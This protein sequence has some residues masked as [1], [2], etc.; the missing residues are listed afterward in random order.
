MTSL[1]NLLI[2]FDYKNPLLLASYFSKTKLTVVDIAYFKAAS[3]CYSSADIIG[4]SSS[5]CS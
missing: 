4:C 3:I 2:S 1:T 5:A